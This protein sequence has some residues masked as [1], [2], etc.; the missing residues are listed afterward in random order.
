MA[1]LKKI[2][3]GIVGCGAIGGSLARM[4][5]KDLS[6]FFK[7]A[8]FCDPREDR[9]RNLL[10]LWPQAKVLPVS[11]LIRSCDLVIESASAAVSGEIAELTLRAGK[12][13]LAM[14]IGGILGKEKELARIAEKKGGR[15][16]LPSGA[17]CGL[18][19][20]RALSL[21][22]IS[23][24][25]LNTYKPPAA[26]V[27]APYLKERGID[28][29]GITQETLVF[30][31]NAKEAVKAFPQNINV[32]ALLQI[33]SGVCV[34]V[35]I[36]ARPGLQKNIHEIQV[37]SA[38]A[39]LKIQCEN[40]ASPDNPKTSYLAILSAAAALKGFSQAVR[41]GA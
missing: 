21:A 15:F 28:L 32:V 38:A 4:I 19:G 27:G 36:W 1:R 22:G 6:P 17:I 26:L 18:D 7:L 3:V 30:S 33:A 37:L 20:I 24:L 29:S 34:Q 40:S 9:A 5:K 14:S 25:T 12:S 13:I 16:L 11:A 31:G 10:K 35:K 39:N 8:A 41:V 2:K 23:S